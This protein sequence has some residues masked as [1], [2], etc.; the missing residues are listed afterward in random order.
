[1]KA[2]ATVLRLL[3][4]FSLAGLSGVIWLKWDNST[5]QSHSFLDEVVSDAYTI[6]Q[7]ERDKQWSDIEEKKN[8]FFEIFDA[9]DPVGQND[10]NPLAIASESLDSAEKG[11]FKSPEYRDS[12]LN[13]NLE[14]GVDSLTWN[15]ESKSWQ[16]DSKLSPPASL[17]DP[18]SDD[19][20]QD[21]K[22]E[23]G[24]I[25]RGVPRANRL[26]TVIGMFYKERD[27]NIKEISKLR[28]M[29]VE[30]DKDLRTFQNL[31][32]KE[33]ERK[34][35]LEEIE[36]ELTVKVA[37]LEE[38][39]KIEKEEREGERQAA[40]EKESELNRL[41]ANLEEQKLIVEKE[42]QDF[43][44]TLR[45]EQKEQ[46]AVLQDEVRKA[47]AEGYK[48][49]IDEMISKQQG[50]EVEQTDVEL[51]VN[52]F[53]PTE[54]GPPKLSQSELMLAA[55]AKEISESGVPS[56]VGRVDGKSGM[57]LLPLGSERGVSLGN[58]Y[59]LWK[60]NKKAARIRIQSVSQGYSLAYLLPQ[61]GSPQDL[62]PGDSVHVVPEI[63][64][65]L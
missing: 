28:N 54:D 7:S 53:L 38:D 12:L 50:G 47:D 37:G 22:K 24:T 10:E 14:Y 16:Q 39:L 62:R 25:I 19:P 20:K 31:H 52:P 61:F 6:L 18:F 17:Q 27:N 11:I 59:T 46:L 51:S 23:D 40:E 5:S 49:G 32:A 21:I 15:S 60:E 56:T 33:K 42:N 64:E 13:L 65:T 63:E 55:Q 57:I 58:V 45:N 30:R 26:R 36:A 43:I 44:N 2:F 4:T 34:E 1:M 48:R 9:N 29:T 8:S 35:E 41:V 3:A